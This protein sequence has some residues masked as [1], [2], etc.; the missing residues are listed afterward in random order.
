MR[1]LSRTL[2]ADGAWPRSLEQTPRDAIIS[3]YLAGSRLFL[4]SALSR[5]SSTFGSAHTRKK[6]VRQQS[7]ASYSRSCI[8]CSAFL[9]GR[10]MIQRIASML[11]RA[12][13]ADRNVVLRDIERRQGPE[14]AHGLGASA[15]ATVEGLQHNRIDVGHLLRLSVRRQTEIF[16][17]VASSAIA[18]IVSGAVFCVASPTLPRPSR[19]A[20]AFHSVFAGIPLS[21]MAGRRFNL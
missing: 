10:T 19:K 8:N 7:R 14:T 11:H 3:E 2:L 21:R 18:R 12:A 5:A 16:S 17:E 4:T 13:A 20:C 6:P 15:P 1:W 9:S